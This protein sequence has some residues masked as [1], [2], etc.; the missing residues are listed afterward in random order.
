MNTLTKQTPS[1]LDPFEET[2]FAMDAAKNTL[3]EMQQWLHQS[4]LSRES[5]KAKSPSRKGSWPS[6]RL[7]RG[8]MRSIKLIRNE[9]LPEKL[10]MDGQEGFWIGSSVTLAAQVSRCFTSVHALSTIKTEKIL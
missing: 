1:K 10:E 2:L 4:R 5:R 7:R 6:V 9:S 8:K 3:A